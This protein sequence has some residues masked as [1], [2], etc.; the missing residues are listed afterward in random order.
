MSYN[1]GSF[2]AAHASAPAYADCCSTYLSVRGPNLVDLPPFKLAPADA[3]A[4][5]LWDDSAALVGI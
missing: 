1:G 5:N 2:L 3:V 4:A